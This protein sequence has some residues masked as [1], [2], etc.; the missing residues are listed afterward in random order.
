MGVIRC[1]V[2]S[3]MVMPE[4]AMRS[5]AVR[6]VNMPR[7]GSPPLLGRL[8]GVDSGDHGVLPTLV[9]GRGM[10]ANHRGQRLPPGC[11]PLGKQSNAQDGPGCWRRLG[12]PEGV[13]AAV[14]AAAS[15]SP[16]PSKALN[17][18]THSTAT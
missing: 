2:E 8:A 15:Q 7:I 6:S 3:V 10:A 9:R 12:I 16:F 11:V 13:P 4:F 14:L 17:A 5:A 1:L 18:F